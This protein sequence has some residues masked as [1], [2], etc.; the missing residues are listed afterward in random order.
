MSQFDRHIIRLD[1]REWALQDPPGRHAMCVQDPLET[2]HNVTER[3]TARDAYQIRESARSSLSVLQ[4]GDTRL[5][6][7]LTDLVT[8][9]HTMSL[10]ARFSSVADASGPITGLLARMGLKGP[11]GA[12]AEGAASGLVGQYVAHGETWVNQRRQRR[13][14]HQDDQF[15]VDEPLD[16]GNDSTEPRGE[17][18]LFRVAVWIIPGKVR[19]GFA[20]FDAFR[21]VLPRWQRRPRPTMRVA[22]P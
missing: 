21:W 19:Q 22:S 18:P 8:R 14:R 1:G 12:I 5:S 16:G 9:K 10:A 7:V 15:R 17:R 2:T 20:L 6:A 4:S 3:L 11:A 13:R